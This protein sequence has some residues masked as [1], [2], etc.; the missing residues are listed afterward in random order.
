MFIERFLLCKTSI[1]FWKN[2]LQNNDKNYNISLSISCQSFVF[3]IYLFYFIIWKYGGGGGNKGIFVL[4]WKREECIRSYYKYYY[5]YYILI[6]LK[7]L[8]YVLDIW[9]ASKKVKSE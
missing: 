2:I 8:G 3:I 4:V 7:Y 9:D 1:L 6:I 5:F